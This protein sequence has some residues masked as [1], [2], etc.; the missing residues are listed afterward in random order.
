MIGHQL[1]S[2]GDQAFKE[3]AGCV[4]RDDLQYA[5]GDVENRPVVE[6]QNPFPI[7]KRIALVHAAAL[8]PQFVQCPHF[9]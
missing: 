4:R 9:I 8:A 6:L 7:L 5:P 3:R 2:G 1:G